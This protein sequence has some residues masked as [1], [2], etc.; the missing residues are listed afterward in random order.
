M[1]SF[2][3]IGTALIL[4]FYGL[5]DSASECIIR[6]FFKEGKTVK[7]SQDLNMFRTYL[8][9]I[10]LKFL[11]I[12]KTKLKILVNQEKIIISGFHEP[13]EA[14]QKKIK[15]YL[16]AYLPKNQLIIYLDDKIL[17]FNFILVPFNML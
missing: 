5:F 11:I 3:D 17:K 10:N 8:D 15:F 9:K 13:F 6:L 16:L 2:L 14:F 4:I 1:L 12:S 7:T